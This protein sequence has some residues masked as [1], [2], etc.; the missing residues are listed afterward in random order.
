MAFCSSPILDH[1]LNPQRVNRKAD[2]TK[3]RLSTQTKEA[4]QGNIRMLRIPQEIRRRKPINIR[5]GSENHPD[6]FRAM[7]PLKTTGDIST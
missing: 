7:P 2:E 1:D 3:D 5:Q 4:V 6:D